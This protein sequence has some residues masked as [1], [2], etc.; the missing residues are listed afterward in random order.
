MIGFVLG[1]VLLSI[2]AVSHAAIIE[3]EHSLI[4]PY[5]GEFLEYFS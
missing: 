5:E 1:F 3:K 4:P 2:I